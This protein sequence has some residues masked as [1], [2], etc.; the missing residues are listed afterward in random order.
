[1]DFLCNYNYLEGGLPANLQFTNIGADWSLNWVAFGGQDAS[2]NFVINIP[3]GGYETY[4][5]AFPDNVSNPFAP[6]LTSQ[7]VLSF[8]AGAYQ[9]HLP[10]GTVEIYSNL[11]AYNQG[12]YFLS[13]V[14]D[15][16][17][18]SATIQYDTYGRL[19]SVTDALGQVSTFTYASNSVVPPM[20][21]YFTLVQ[22]TDPFGRSAYFN[23]NIAY[24][25]L[26][27]TD[28]IGITSTF[29]SYSL[30]TPY[31][32]TTFQTYTPTAPSLTGTGLKFIFPDNTSAVVENWIDEACK[33]YFWNRE[34]FGLYPNDYV[35]HVYS[36]CHTT[37]WLLV[38]EGGAGLLE[39]P[40][41]DFDLPPL[42]NRT[43]YTYAGETTDGDHNFIGA[44]N[45]PIQVSR[46]TTGTT[47][48]NWNM[49]NNALGKVT[50]YQDPVGPNRC[51]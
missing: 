20:V 51:L 1:M 23:Q 33:S 3:G 30:T 18:N 8:S 45:R 32:T 47:T 19:T 40:V 31:G 35:N 29:T 13:A 11:N 25:G 5:Y 37:Q 9:R 43:T 49:Q 41:P 34:Q 21:G 10:D 38:G 36:H 27:I 17:G 4:E 6:N 16:Q 46:V 28:V 15:P 50:Q 42:E 14:I 39:S 24:G 2:G 44:I 26:A 12:Y 7:A 22:I 48:Q